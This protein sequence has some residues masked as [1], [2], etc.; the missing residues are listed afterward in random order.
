MKENTLSLRSCFFPW[1]CCCR[2]RSS[3]GWF[4]NKEREDKPYQ[5]K[6]CQ[7]VE[8]G[9]GVAGP[10]SKAS[11]QPF[12]TRQTALGIEHQEQQCWNWS[13]SRIGSQPANHQSQCECSPI[14]QGYC[15]IPQNPTLFYQLWQK[16]H[17]LDVCGHSITRSRLLGCFFF[18]AVWLR[19]STAPSS[20]L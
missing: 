6:S 4:C 1:C 18:K 16:H 8:F 15:R 14:S 11:Q 20:P 5:Q 13:W 10:F 12:W 3:G 17:N 7:G 9:F 19:S 2:Q